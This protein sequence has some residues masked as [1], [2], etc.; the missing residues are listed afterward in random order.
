MSHDFAEKVALLLLT[1]A[2]SGF[3]IPYILRHVDIRRSIEQRRREA[4]IARQ[5]KLIEAQSSLLEKVSAELW[6]WRYSFMKVTYYGS[7][8]EP[9]RYEQAWKDYTESIWSNLNQIR[10]QISRTRWLVSEPLYDK[11]LEF[12]YI[13]IKYDNKLFQVTLIEDE[14]KRSLELSDLNHEVFWKVSKAIDLL[15]NDLASEVSLSAESQIG[16]M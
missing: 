7:Q 3:L 12:Y 5:A 10:Y 6:K 14:I 2:I 16:R 4:R 9:Q 11:I 15:I 13:I 8:G 1:T